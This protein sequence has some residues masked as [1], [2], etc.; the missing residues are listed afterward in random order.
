MDDVVGRAKKI[1]EAIDG[2]G[3]PYGPDAVISPVLGEYFAR[4]LLAAHE[5][6]KELE[7][8][9]VLDATDDKN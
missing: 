9:N 5:R 2:R 7:A 1:I 4:A 6:I 8:A 3:W